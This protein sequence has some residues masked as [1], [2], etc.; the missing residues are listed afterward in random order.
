MT[1]FHKFVNFP[2]EIRLMIWEAAVRSDQPGVQI[3]EIR[4]RGSDPS[5]KDPT[6]LPV[7]DSYELQ[8]VQTRA[9]NSQDDFGASRARW[10][11]NGNPSTCLVDHGLWI[12]CKESRCV[13]ARSQHEETSIFTDG[14]RLLAVRPHQDLFLIQIDGPLDIKLESLRQ[15]ESQLWRHPSPKPHQ[16]A[17]E[18]DPS[19]TLD[20]PLTEPEH[21]LDYWL[22]IFK[23]IQRLAWQVETFGRLWIVDHSLVRQSTDACGLGGGSTQEPLASFH[24]EGYKLVE[25]EMQRGLWTA[26][27]LVKWEY[28]KFEDGRRPLDTTIDF[29][30]HIRH[31][32]FLWD[33]EDLM[34]NVKLLALERS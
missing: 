27:S 26:M 33:R 10:W 29:V 3:F 34:D 31:H 16:V 5:N 14:G 23:T 4:N 30:N 15:Q 8:L 17:F 19:W 1:T 13:I 25:V 12:A 21:Y 18:Y 24:A 9:E 28:T 32:L 22:R 11:R 6:G 7:D 20:S 2:P